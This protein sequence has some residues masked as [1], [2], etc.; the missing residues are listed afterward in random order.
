MKYLPSC[1]DA[2]DRRGTLPYRQYFG[3]PRGKGGKKRGG[4]G[5]I[6]KPRAAPDPSAGVVTITTHALRPGE[7]KRGEGWKRRS[8]IY[9]L[10]LA[11]AWGLAQIQDLNNFKPPAGQSKQEKKKSKEVATTLSPRSSLAFSINSGEGGKGEKKERKS[12]ARGPSPARQEDAR[13]L[14]RRT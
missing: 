4:R 13:Y 8:R 3:R 14:G 2:L 7:E 11:G 5:N 12:S 9:A 6:K 1:T 10:L